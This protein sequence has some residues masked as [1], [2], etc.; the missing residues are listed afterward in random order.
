MDLPVVG[1]HCA[2]ASCHELDFLPIRCRCD[3][4]YCRHHISPE[5]HHCVVEPSTPVVNATFEKL[6]RCALDGC[7]KPS[8]ESFVAGSG[9][10]A[11]RSPAVCSA[12]NLSF[13]ASHRHAASHSCHPQ[14]LPTEPKNEAARALLHKHFPSSSTT[15]MEPKP[16]RSPKVPSDPKKLAQMQKLELMKM[17]HRAAP[18]DPRDKSA[19]L[20]MDQRLHLRVSLGEID[21]GKVFWFRKVHPCCT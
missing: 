9:T 12:C 4:F 20:G 6:V 14:E 10:T 11:G 15:K 1:A 16:L 13:C 2:L 3:K 17:R 7:N 8:L 18:G 5:T 19:S 21:D